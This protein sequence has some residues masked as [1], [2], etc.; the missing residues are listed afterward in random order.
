MRVRSPLEERIEAIW[1]VVGG[2]RRGG[3]KGG[4]HTP[5]K[6]RFSASMTHGRK[7]LAKGRSLCPRPIFFPPVKN[8]LWRSPATVIPPQATSP[9]PTK[10]KKPLGKSEYPGHSPTYEPQGKREKPSDKADKQYRHYH[11]GQQICHQ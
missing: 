4:A 9:L 10:H 11:Y 1:R 6:W 7:S 5:E 2:I 8:C 3:E